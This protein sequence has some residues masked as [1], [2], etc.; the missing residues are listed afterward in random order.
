MS[1]TLEE[2][3]KLGPYKAEVQNQSKPKA[4]PSYGLYSFV[5]ESVQLIFV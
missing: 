4:Y 5:S 3:K 1:G 2:R